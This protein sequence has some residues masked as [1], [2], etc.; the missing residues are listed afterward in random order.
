MFEVYLTLSLSQSSSMLWKNYY[1]THLQIKVFVCILSYYPNI[2]SLNKRV[3]GGVQTSMLKEKLFCDI[4]LKGL[5][6]PAGARNG[7]NT[8]ENMFKST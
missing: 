7:R 2:V 1:K 6:P 8:C 5:E 4:C 3:R